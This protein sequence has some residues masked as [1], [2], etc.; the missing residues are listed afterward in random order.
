MKRDKMRIVRVTQYYHRS[1]IAK[2]NKRAYTNVLII[3][4][5]LER[6]L[7]KIA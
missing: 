1:L 5:Y 4:S 2:Y 7:V 3:N 6:S